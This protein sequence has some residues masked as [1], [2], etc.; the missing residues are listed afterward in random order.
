MLRFYFLTVG[1]SLP[2][3]PIRTAIDISLGPRAPLSPEKV[4][5]RGRVL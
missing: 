5:K 2:S 3:R 1:N 4:G